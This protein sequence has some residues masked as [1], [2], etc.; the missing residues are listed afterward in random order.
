[1]INPTFRN[2]NRL[3][4]L[5]FLNDSNDQVGD[6]FDQ[7][8]LPLLEIKDLNAF[9]D[10]KPFF[11]IPIKT[12]KKQMKNL[13]RCQETMNIQKET[14]NSS[15]IQKLCAIYNLWINNR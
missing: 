15:S 7:Y 9:T 5:L 3:F 10:N 14:S 2:I 11:D 8:Y 1:M 12:S 13:W 6:S 4:A